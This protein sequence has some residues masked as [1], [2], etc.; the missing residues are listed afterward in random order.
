[1]L[2]ILSSN[3]AYLS[4]VLENTSALNPCIQAQQS[5]RCFIVHILLNRLYRV[6]VNDVA[7]LCHPISISTMGGIAL[8]RPTGFRSQQ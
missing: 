2:R 4:S 1:M 6:V 7:Y 3:D 5:E 8:G